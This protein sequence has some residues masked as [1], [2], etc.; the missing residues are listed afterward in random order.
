MEAQV[1]ERASSSIVLDNPAPQ[2]KLS[3]SLLGGFE[4][5]LGSR[6]GHLPMAGQRVLVF[7]ALHH[8]SLTRS[9]VS[10]ALWLDATE[11]HADGNLR[12]ALWRIGKLE[13]PL[14]EKTDG[15]IA[16][17]PSVNVDLHRSAY[18]ATRL[19]N[20]P[21]SV[22]E[23]ELHEEMLLADLLPDWHD[24]WI[25]QEQQLYRQLRLH[26]LES[27][28]LRLLSLGRWGRA[29]QAGLAAV[30][31][32]PLGERANLALIHA[33]LGEGNA[34]EALRQYRSFETL[35]QDELGIGPT[36]AFREAFQSMGGPLT[37]R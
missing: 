26:A 15:H 18:L 11:S 25:V 8:R 20:D 30:A 1:K 2:Q 32:E 5:R 36:R 28:C 29:I 13:A 16:L 33:Y 12:Y 24:E 22:D 7:L 9:Y 37:L 6:V 17:D 23:S 35:L 14:I 19:Q 34:G 4:L 27:L 21:E 31:G 10:Q 3:L